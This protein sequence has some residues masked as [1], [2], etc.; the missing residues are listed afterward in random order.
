MINDSSSRISEVRGV[1]NHIC[2]KA[3][4]NPIVIAMR[5]ASEN[6]LRL[7]KAE[8][9]MFVHIFLGKLFKRELKCR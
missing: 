4:K 1:T 5:L 6:V 2:G 7:I 9:G 8:K 3:V